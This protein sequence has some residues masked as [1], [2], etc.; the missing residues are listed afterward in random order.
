MPASKPA[1]PPK[2]VASK[3]MRVEEDEDDDF[4]KEFE[5][6]VKKQKDR[7]KA[8]LPPPQAVLGVR[9]SSTANNPAALQQPEKLSKPPKGG[10]VNSPPK[11]VA[12]QS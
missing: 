2:P 4:D 6:I 5:A 1:I 11:S 12:V 3:P 10:R 7:E 9:S 8:R